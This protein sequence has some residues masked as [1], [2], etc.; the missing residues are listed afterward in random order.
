MD[1]CQLRQ[2]AREI[3]REG[4]PALELGQYERE[5]NVADEGRSLWTD[6]PTGSQDKKPNRR[7]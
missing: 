3:S 2:G 1:V 7:R 6:R 4:W 5:E